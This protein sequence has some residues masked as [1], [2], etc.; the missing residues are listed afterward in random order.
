M[1][2]YVLLAFVIGWGLWYIIFYFRYKDGN[3]I[4]E[5]DLEPNDMSI[6]S[7]SNRLEYILKKSN[8]NR[9]I[10]FGEIAQ[11]VVEIKQ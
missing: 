4:G 7:C 2:A 9:I 8:Y 1:D 6:C 11:K 3:V 5:W 10:L